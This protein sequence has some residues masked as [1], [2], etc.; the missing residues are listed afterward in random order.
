[1]KSPPS[2]ADVWVTCA[3][4]AALQAA[5]P[6]PQVDTGQ[7]PDTRLEGKGFDWLIKQCYGKASPSSF[8]GELSP[9]G[10]VVDDEMVEAC[11][12]YTQIIGSRNCSIEVKVKL[13]FLKTGQYGYIDALSIDEHNK[14]IHIIDAKYGHSYVDEFENYQLS[15]YL[16][17]ILDELGK[18]D[19]YDWSFELSIFQ[20]RC[21]GESTFRTWKLGYEDIAKMGDIFCDAVGVSMD[22]KPPTT[23]GNH[24][25]K[26]NARHAC[27]AFQKAVYDGY[28]YVGDS[29]PMLLSDDAIALE[30]KI[31]K[32]FETQLKG[33]LSGIEQDAMSRLQSGKVLPGLTGKL[34]TGRERWKKDTNVEEVINISA[35]LGVEDCTKPKDLITPKQLIKKG[36]DRAVINEYIESPQGKFTISEIN[37]KQL[38]KTFKV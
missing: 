14:T 8:L 4:A 27:S 38:R 7:Q 10:V 6:L 15:I 13:D 28:Q 16:L 12:D 36:V 31:L 18:N 22:E 23:V 26:C 5:N 35:L 29:V 24:C 17:G 20:P 19:Y 33:R 34:S 32:Q 21:F 30:Y 37:Q 2:N 11:E 3:G 1:M 9:D 25:K